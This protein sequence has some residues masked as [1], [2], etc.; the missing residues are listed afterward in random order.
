M[1]DA[2]ECLQHPY[3]L[4]LDGIVT[5]HKEMGIDLADREQEGL[6]LVHGWFIV[7]FC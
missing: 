2:H 4:L 7:V 1:P 6:T 5:A 3:L